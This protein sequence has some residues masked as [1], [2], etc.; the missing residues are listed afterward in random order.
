MKPIRKAFLFV[1]SAALLGACFDQPEFSN[2]PSIEYQG[3][4][5]GRTPRGLDSLAVSMSFKDG[6]GDMGLD[7]TL[8]VDSPYHAFNF[9]AN[10]NGQ[11]APLIVYGV[12]NFTGVTLLNSKK[13]PRGF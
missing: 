5:F 13:K 12:S 9:F 8:D 1:I 2:I 3:I 4:Y 11:L 6:D 7:G 10:D